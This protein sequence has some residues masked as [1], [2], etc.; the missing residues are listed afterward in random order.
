[1]SSSGVTAGASATS[2]ATFMATTPNMSS[3]NRHSPRP[4]R[5]TSPTTAMPLPLQTQSC[6]SKHPH[7]RKIQEQSLNSCPVPTFDPQRRGS[8]HSPL[9][10]HERRSR[11]GTGSGTMER[12]ERD[13]REMEDEQRRELG[14]MYIEMVDADDG[15]PSK[16]ERRRKSRALSGTKRECEIKEIEQEQKRREQELV[17]LLLAHKEDEDRLKELEGLKGDGI[18]EEEVQN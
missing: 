2:I 13:W 12:R 5:P 18:E 9:S 4:S 14:V 10:P 15:P 3:T 17:R 6:E 11:A 1:M 16:M 8:T 7:P